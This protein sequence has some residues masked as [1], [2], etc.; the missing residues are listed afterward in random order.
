MMSAASTNRAPHP[1]NLPRTHSEPGA[2]TTGQ[3]YDNNKVAEV[4][5]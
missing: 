4:K 2:S 1:R 5:H 3:T